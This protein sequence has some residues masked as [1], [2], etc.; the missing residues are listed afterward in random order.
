MT[1]TNGEGKLIERGNTK[2]DGTSTDHSDGSAGISP[3]SVG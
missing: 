2:E 1:L 3:G